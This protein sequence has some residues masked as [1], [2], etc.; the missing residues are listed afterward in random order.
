MRIEEAR[1]LAEWIAEL[2]LP[3][4]TVCLNV[5]S[6]TG[7]FRQQTQPH[8]HECLFAP[9]EAAGLHVVHCDMKSAEGVDEVGDLLDPQF[10]AHLRT[11][12]AKVL[13]CSNLLEHLTKPLEFAAACGELVV[14]GGHGLFSVP[15]DYPY[16]PDPI[17]TMLRPSPDELAGMLPGWKVE[18][19]EV[20]ESGTYRD[21]LR[22]SGRPW[23]VLSRQ[24]ARVALPF[25]RPSQWRHLAHRLLWLGRSYKVSL[26]QLQKPEAPY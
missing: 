1:R 22:A 2:D 24:L 20:V 11:Y 8:I 12:R 18:R 10:R 4:G 14:P 26:V 21:D 6:S 17:D 7:E 3:R 9:L 5:G 19:Q 16:H 25:Y 23:A 13:I 15:Y